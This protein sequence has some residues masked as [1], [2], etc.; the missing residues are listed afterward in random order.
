MGRNSLSKIINDKLDILTGEWE[1]YCKS[2]EL[3]CMSAEEM[4]TVQDLTADQKIYIDKFIER[5]D[6]CASPE[7][8]V[9]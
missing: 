4:D 5:W 2:Q 6:E 3:E 7:S 9:S 8:A 1:R